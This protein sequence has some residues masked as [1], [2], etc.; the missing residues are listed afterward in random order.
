MWIDTHCHPFS[1]PLKADLE[2]VIERAL[3]ADV[4]KMIVVGY[5]QEGNREVMKLIEA[6]DF[7]WGALGIHPCD[8]KELTDEE[9]AWIR[10]TA[11]HPKVVAIGEM[12]LDYHHMSSPKDVQAEVFR[13]QIRLAKELD[14]PCVVHSRDAAEDT[15]AILLEEG[16]EKVV[17]HCYSYGPEFGKRVWEAGYYTSFSGVLTYPKA[18]EIQEAARIAPADKILIETDCPYL[19]P[20]S[21]RGKRNEMAYVAEVGEK[22]AE[23]RGLSKQQLASQ[24]EENVGCLFAVYSLL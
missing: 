10:E 14:L 1:K 2:G 4:K 13:K 7:M 9:L 15:L 17:F 12:G 11:A 6:H 19:A 5:S 8:C 22:L 21:V 24:L 3:D 16:A 18:L 23:L 20:Q